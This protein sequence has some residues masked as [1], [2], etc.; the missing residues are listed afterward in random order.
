VK[1]PQAHL[2]KKDCLQI[3]AEA[4]YIYKR[5]GVLWEEA[6]KLA[7]PVRETFFSEDP[8]QESVV[9]YLT[10]N[11]HFSKFKGQEIWTSINPFKEF[12]KKAQNQIGRI[13]TKLGFKNKSVTL[14]IKGEDGLQRRVAKMYVKD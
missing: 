7:D 1:I 4:I 11:A 5:D 2:I 6:Q 14:Q 12:D 3:W 10:Q 13:M 8:L 9:E